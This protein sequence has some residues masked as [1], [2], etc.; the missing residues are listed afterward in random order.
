[1]LPPST[2]RDL[3]KFYF[4]EGRLWDV[5]V[6][7]QLSI[8]DKSAGPP[9]LSKRCIVCRKNINLAEMREHVASHIVKGGI[10]GANICGLWV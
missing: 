10:V 9:S 4:D 2:P 5:G 1:M 6:N 3:Q 7:L 8:Q